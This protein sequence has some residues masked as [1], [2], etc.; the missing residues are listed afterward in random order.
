MSESGLMCSDARPRRVVLLTGAEL[1]HDF[2]RVAVSLQDGIAVP[3]SVTEGREG[4]LQSTLDPSLPG[5]SLQ[6]QHLAQRDFSERDFF[7]AFVAL[8]PDRSHPLPIPRGTINSPDVFSE[9]SAVEPDLLVAYGPSL[10]REPL[11]ARYAGRFVNVHL[12]LSPYYTGSGTNF[13]ALVNGEPECVG[14]TLMHI[15]GGIDTGAII[16]QIRARIYPGDGPHQIGNRLIA[17]AVSAVIHLIRHADELGHGIRPARPPTA[18]HYRKKDFTP[19]AVATLYA[20]FRSGLV[21]RYHAELPERTARVPVH[22]HPLFA[23]WTP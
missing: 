9:I 7:G 13:W 17:D 3:R 21:E 12:G 1:R 10:V 11:L 20:N 6:A 23:D 5:S 2:F 8:A 15:D 18:R 16:H 19:E 22:E 14:A 4:T